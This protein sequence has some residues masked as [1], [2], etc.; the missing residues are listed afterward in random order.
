MAPFTKTNARSLRSN[1][2]AAEAQL[3]FYLRKHATGFKFRRQHPVG[4][5]IV[6]F[7]CATAHL[8]IE[9]D[10]GQ[11]FEP[12]GLQKDAARTRDIQARGLK[13]IRFTNTEVL[14]ETDSVLSVIL[15]ALQ[16]LSLTLSPEGRGDQNGIRSQ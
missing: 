5:Y 10:G 2:T 8:V 13:V 4:P 15:E 6:D 16:P 3:W 11:H 12:D 14:H 9:V 1:Q 7:Y